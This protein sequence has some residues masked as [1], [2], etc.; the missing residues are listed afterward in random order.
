VGGKRDKAVGE[1]SNAPETSTTGFCIR[2]LLAAIKSI[3]ARFGGAAGAVIAR[4]SRPVARPA[5]R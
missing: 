3:A 5:D 2:I 1:A 4:P